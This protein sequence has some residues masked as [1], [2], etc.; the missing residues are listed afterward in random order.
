MAHW[1]MAHWPMAFLNRQPL[2]GQ[3]PC[4]D[5][6]VKKLQYLK[7]VYPTAVSLGIEHI[8]GFM[9]KYFVNGSFSRQTQIYRPLTTVNYLIKGHFI[10]SG[11]I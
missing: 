7:R 1:P 4:L 3:F 10:S 6:I 8:F 5:Y 11:R 2:F 9:L